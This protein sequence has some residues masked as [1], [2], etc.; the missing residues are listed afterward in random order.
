M[1]NKP[2]LYEGMYIINATLSEEASKKALDK[3]TSAI[4]GKGGVVNKIHAQGRKKLA[5]EINGSKQGY[6][7][8]IYFSIDP[9][10]IGELWKDYQLNEDLVRYTTLRTSHVLETLEFKSLA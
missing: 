8:V 10:M 7:F 4:E 5:Y 1:S 3:I 9:A 6:Y 2:V